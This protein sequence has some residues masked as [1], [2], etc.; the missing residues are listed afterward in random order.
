META[1]GCGKAIESAIAFLL[2]QRTY[3]G[4]ALRIPVRMRTTA[5]NAIITAH[6][7]TEMRGLDGT[8]ECDM[9][10]KLLCK[11]FSEEDQ[12]SEERTRK[13]RISDNNRRRACTPSW[14]KRIVR[15]VSSLG[16]FLAL[17]ETNGKRVPMN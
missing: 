1:R 13:S 6:V 16:F 10:V 9:R 15:G 7:S 2:L 11:R 5:N 3:Q 8:G 17:V 4:M 14:R 12:R